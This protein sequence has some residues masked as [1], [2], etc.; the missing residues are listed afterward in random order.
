MGELRDRFRASNP[1]PTRW[2]RFAAALE[3]TRRRYPLMTIGALATFVAIS[4][5]SRSEDV[6]PSEIAGILDQPL[7]TIF[8]QCDQLSDG[9][10][11]KPGMGLIKKVPGSVDARE[12]VLKVSL[13][14]LK[15]LTDLSE[16]LGTD[17]DELA[18]GTN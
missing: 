5:A 3:Y 9:V 7:T 1:N 15:L 2:D 13:S 10:R 11:G 4:K 17:H 12:R 16:L 6:T 8:R 14:G 18:H